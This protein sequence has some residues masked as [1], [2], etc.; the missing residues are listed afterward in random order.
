MATVTVEA[1]NPV[2]AAEIAEPKLREILTA[3]ID[4]QPA[5]MTVEGPDGRETV[6]SFG[7]GL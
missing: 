5:E 1:A 4:E 7:G 3:H 2:F 6:F